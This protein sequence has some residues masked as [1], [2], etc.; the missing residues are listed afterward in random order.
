MIH[1]SK[2][3]SCC[4]TGDHPQ[5]RQSGISEHSQMRP[6]SVAFLTLPNIYQKPSAHHAQC[7][8]LSGVFA[9]KHPFSSGTPCTD[10]ILRE[11]PQNDTCVNPKSAPCHAERSLRSEASPFVRNAVHRRD[12]SGG[13]LAYYP[14]FTQLLS[15]M[16]KKTL[17]PATSHHTGRLP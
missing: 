9:A 2:N 11:D 1:C 7:V 4:A 8:I 16:Q 6:S 12:S 14:P 10:G 15:L 17:P 5:K 13:T 3:G